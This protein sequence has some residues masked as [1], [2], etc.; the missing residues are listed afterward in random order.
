MG[1]KSSGVFAV[2]DGHGGSKAADFC[3]DKIIES[4]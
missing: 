2:L 1:L 4:L 3:K